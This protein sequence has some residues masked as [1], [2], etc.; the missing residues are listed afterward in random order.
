MAL[1][2][3]SEAIEDI[4][5]GKIIIIV[6]D[7]N[8]ENEGDFAVAAEKI[9]PDLINFMAKYGR[10]LICMPI[11]NERLEELKIPLMVSDNTAPLGTAFTVSIEAKHRVSTGIS[12][13][14]RAET[15]K[16][17]IHPDTRPDDIVRPGHMFPIAARKGGVLV[18]AG[19]T[20][21]IV[22]LAKLANLYPAG[23]ICEIMN[24]DGTMA[25]LPQL[26]KI[27]DKF[28]LKMVSIADLI[29]YRRRTEKLIRRVA[30]AKLPTK[31]G[32]F[33]MIAF[34]KKE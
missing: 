28:G 21:A 14:D 19:H 16:T 11:I 1:S 26:E 25:R 31:Y 6:D 4:K 17:V 27:T 15:I 13:H 22:D 7:E 24:E 2:T 32:E 18:R 12:A 23:V 33:K 3:I 10:G 9:T 30:E 34:E 5:S 8:R 20:E 29:S